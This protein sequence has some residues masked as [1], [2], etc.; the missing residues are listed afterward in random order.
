PV[1]VKI[2]MEIVS[3]PTGD[4]AVSL[5]PIYGTA[6]ATFTGAFRI[7]QPRA[8]RWR[9]KEPAREKCLSINAFTRNRRL[10]KYSR[11]ASA[12]MVSTWSGERRY[13]P[14]DRGIWKAGSAGNH[15]VV[16]SCEE[17]PLE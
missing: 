9:A 15:L 7:S 12:T 16:I 1:K 10:S 13:R 6:R 4:T 2:R 3:E 11:P 8:L 14:P 5:V 17:L